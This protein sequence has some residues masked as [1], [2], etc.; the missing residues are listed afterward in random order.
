MPTI[1]NE[2]IKWLESPDSGVEL[3]GQV[4]E[5][6]RQNPKRPAYMSF[7][8]PDDWS[9]NAGGNE[10]LSDTYLILRIPRERIDELDSVDEKVDNTVAEV[11]PSE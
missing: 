9:L 3:R 8:V 6:A 1:R 10:K 11:V 7:F 4:F 5:T 2:L